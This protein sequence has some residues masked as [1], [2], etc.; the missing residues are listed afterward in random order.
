[1]I[2][3][4]NAATSYFKPAQVVKAVAESVQKYSAN[5]GRGGHEV[6]LKAAEKVYEARELLNS[7]FNG[8]ASEYVS[9]TSNC[10]QALNIAIKGILKKG[11]HVIISCF[12]H[13]SVVRPLEKLK[14]DGFVEYSVFNVCENEEET[15]KSFEAAFQNNTK[16]C[17]CTA[18]SNVFGTV[19]P[20]KKHSE[21]AHKKGALFFVD[22]AQ[23]A[24]VIP[25]D[26]KKQGID[27]LCV[28]GHKGLLGPMG[29]GAVLHKNL[30]FDTVIEGGTGTDSFSVNQPKYYPERLESGTL[31]VPGICGLG[32]GIKFL[33]KYGVENIFNKETML[34]EKL[35]YG[36]KSIPGVTLYSD[37]YNKKTQAPLVSFN[38]KKHHSESVAAALNEYGIAVRGG[39]HCSFCAHK[40]MGTESAGTVRVS[41]SINNSEKDVNF[42]LNLLKKFAFIK[43]I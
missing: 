24:G 43:Y 30:D 29:T 25:L 22:G 13:N 14:C 28:P 19:L 35:F 3:F 38:F 34:C 32:E 39:Y 27:C 6:S 26:M 20:L 41:P 8:Y 21:I 18:V 16:L 1:M 7:F 12:E 37:F 2:Y 40:F 23:G 5:P 4:D 11:D 42:L 17:I 10:T 36:L 15:L 31:N 33:N 9:F